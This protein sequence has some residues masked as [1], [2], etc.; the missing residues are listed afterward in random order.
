[1]FAREA[2]FKDPQRWSPYAYGRGNP[3]RH[4][5][6]TGEFPQI[7]GAVII[8]RA[9]GAFA[10]TAGHMLTSRDWSL[11]TLQEK[12]LEGAAWGAFGALTGGVGIA[13]N[14]VANN[15]ISCGGAMVQEFVSTK[16]KDNYDA[17]YTQACINAVAGN[18]ASKNLMVAEKQVL[19]PY[20]RHPVN[21]NLP[22]NL[23]KHVSQGLSDN[24]VPFNTLKDISAATS[25]TT[26]ANS[27]MS[28]RTPK[29]DSKENGLNS[30]PGDSTQ[31]ALNDSQSEAG[32]TKVS[33]SDSDSDS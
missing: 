24:E 29:D 2:R 7:V 4:S 11:D 31:G 27:L 9:V 21:K 23:K 8:G 14:P 30:S 22:N 15:M 6:P 19:N 17:K 10:N 20:G 1:M 26:L 18:F 25:V 16:M 5:D 12:A 28:T 33:D 13:K 32:P 3:L